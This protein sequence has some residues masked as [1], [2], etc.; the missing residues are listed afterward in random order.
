MILE[1]QHQDSLYP[2]DLADRLAPLLAAGEA[3]LGPI[4][5]P[6]T[7]LEVLGFEI[8]AG[9]VR[10]PAGAERLDETLIVA[11]LAQRARLW[12]AD[13]AVLEVVGSTSTILNEIAARRSVQGMVR[14]AELQILGRGRR[15]KHW[16]SPYASNLA[17]SLGVRLPQSPDQLGGFSLCVGLAVADGLSRFGVPGIALKWPNDVLVNGRKIAGILVELH[18]SDAGTEVVIG[19]G[20][21]F[22]LPEA[23]R[24]EIDQ[25]ATDLE[26]EGLH[27]SRNRVASGLISSIV[28]FVAAFAEQGFAPMTGAFDA[29]HRYHGQTCNLLLGRE[30]VS[31]RVVGVSERGELLLEADG[32]VRAYGAGEVSLRPN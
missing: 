10:L 9:K 21:N 7:T 4:G 6:Q 2:E 1:M 22:R 19:V 28:D 23:A 15:G 27:L 17:L 11:A 18:R 13:L 16:I 26:A 32:G 5:L 14:L 25:P 31:G 12:L 24:A 20:I 3:D 29:L 8:R 30:T